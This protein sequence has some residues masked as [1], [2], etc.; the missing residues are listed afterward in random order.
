MY[1]YMWSGSLSRRRRNVSPSIISDADP[2]G[3]IVR[4]MQL[5]AT[6]PWRHGFGHELR[7]DE[8]R[9]DGGSEAASWCSRLS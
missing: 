4:G 3:V 8:L 9:C 1:T 7:C 6:L 5:V 2:D